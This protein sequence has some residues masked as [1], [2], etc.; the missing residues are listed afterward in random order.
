MKRTIKSLFCLSL[1]ILILLA[2]CVTAG[3][4][5][6]LPPYCRDEG[7][8]L[9]SSQE[10]ELNDLLQETSDRL[11]L[12]V[13][14]CTVETLDGDDVEDVAR[15][16]FKYVNHPYSDGVLLLVAMEEREWYIYTAGEGDDYLTN[17]ALDD[18]KDAVVSH[19]KE[20][21]YHEAFCAYAALCDEYLTMGKEGNPYRGSF[22]LGQNILI[23]LVIGVA[24]GLITVSVM[25]S[26]LKSVRPRREAHE[27][28][29]PGSMHVTVSRDLFLYRTI[30]RRP[31]PKD[32]SSGSRSGGSRSGGRGGR[33]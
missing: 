21:D 17:A 22:P 29:R 32:S 1:A 12:T 24:V 3:A 30:H 4:A 28:T 11:Q 13:A 20:D 26:K 10:E 33:F 6:T 16:Q 9:T 27:Y 25:R 18:I 15:R 14:V 23:A 31:K 7:S 19:L 8:A 2:L 5:T